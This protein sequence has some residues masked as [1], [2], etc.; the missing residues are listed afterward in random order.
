MAYNEPERF[1]I[2]DDIASVLRTDSGTLRPDPGYLFS[3]ETEIEVRAGE[4]AELRL[5][6]R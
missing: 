4:T 1:L 6:M 5:L 3:A 2:E